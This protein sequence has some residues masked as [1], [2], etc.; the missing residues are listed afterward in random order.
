VEAV[1]RTGCIKTR[2]HPFQV[3]AGVPPANIGDS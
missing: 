3:H 2:D 1:L